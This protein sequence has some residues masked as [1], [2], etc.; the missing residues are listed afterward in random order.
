L[1]FL[2][3]YKYVLAAKFGLKAS[4]PVTAAQHCLFPY[5]PAAKCRQPLPPRGTAV[6]VSNRQVS[7]LFIGHC[8]QA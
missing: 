1:F 7:M 8:T 4:L 6:V 3:F 2:R 5:G